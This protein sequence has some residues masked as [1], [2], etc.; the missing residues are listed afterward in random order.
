ML[1]RDAADGRMWIGGLVAAA[2]MLLAGI[3][4]VPLLGQE[5]ARSEGQRTE[6]ARRMYSGE[7]LPDEAVK[8]FAHAD[9]LFAVRVVR[10][11]AK[12]RELPAAAKRLRNVR[13]TSAGKTYDL[14]DYLALNRVTGILVLKNGRVALEDY[15]LGIG[16][17]TRWPSFS[18]AKSVTSTLVGAALLDGAIH[19][20][21]DRVTNYVPA[22]QGGAYDGVSV[23]NVLQMASGVKWD[24]TYT[25][26]KSDRRKL[27]EWQ[28]RPEPKPGY[29]LAFM[30]A[31]GKAGEPGSI[32]NYN[33]G[34]T[35]V[36]GAVV[37]G[38][39]HKRLGD[40]ATEKIWGPWGMEANAHWWLETPE[41]MGFGGGGLE[42]TLRDFGRIGLLVMA[43]GVID[44]KRLVPAGW[45]DEAGN[46]KSVGGKMVDYGYLWWPLP[47]GDAVHEG[48]F[49]AIGIFGQH[50][51]VNRR[52]KLVVMVLSAR[53]KPTGSTVVDD[54]AFFAAVVKEM[55]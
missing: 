54:D 51:Y 26:P 53:P 5:V 41:G 21:D 19:S 2:T 49:E 48:A 34:E 11:G 20:L 46:A 14:F 1:T 38:A 24:E 8:A 52:E 4:N 6:V 13:F 33:T 37:E 31:L 28:L 15:E 47:K 50:M 3:A 17:Q 30:S 7:M 18:V 45:F 40:Y 39:T 27:L 44:G 23:R 9:E 42:A 35:F 32:W 25:D 10:H 29:I 36:V 16:P 55:R 12:V 22:L 43:D